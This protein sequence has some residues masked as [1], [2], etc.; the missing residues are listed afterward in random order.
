MTIKL[1]YT[2]SVISSNKRLIPSRGRFISGTKYR[3]FK[4]DMAMTWQLQSKHRNVGEFDIDIYC[5][6]NNRLDHHNLLKPILD[7]L[8]DAVIIQNDKLAGKVTMH[9]AVRSNKKPNKIYL[10]ITFT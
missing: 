6:V 7:S 10:K 8:Q 1:F 3:N 5:R 9:K 2:G 4:T